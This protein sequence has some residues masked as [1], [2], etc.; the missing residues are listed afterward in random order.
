VRLEYGV[1]GLDLLKRHVRRA[2]HNDQAARQGVRA[3]RV[4]HA[5][6][7]PRGGR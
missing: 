1:A 2:D 7:G 6:R 3:A 4:L 5:Q